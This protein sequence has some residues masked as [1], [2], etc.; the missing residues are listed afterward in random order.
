MWRKFLNSH[1]MSQ[2]ARICNG[3]KRSV[4][5]P[6]SESGIDRRC[7]AGEATKPSAKTLDA[8]EPPSNNITL[9]AAQHSGRSQVHTTKPAWLAIWCKAFPSHH[10]RGSIINSIDLP[11]L[12]VNHPMII[13]CFYGRINSLGVA[14][15][16]GC[17]SSRPY[18]YPRA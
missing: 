8:Q 1:I 2:S 15:V 18:S 11:Q 13:R 16:A 17:S 5:L 10:P 3:M 9:S 14:I 6:A 7:N 4:S 12:G